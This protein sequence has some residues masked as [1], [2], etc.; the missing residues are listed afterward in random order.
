MVCYLFRSRPSAP[1]GYLVVEVRR[2]LP[3]VDAAVA[4]RD[5]SG[6]GWIGP[7]GIRA[8]AKEF[9]Q[10]G[11]HYIIAT[12]GLTTN[13]GWEQGGSSYAE[14]AERELIRSGVSKNKIIVAPAREA[15]SRRTYESAV[16]VWQALGQGYSSRCPQCVH[17][18]SSRQAKSFGFRKGL[19]ARNASWRRRLGSVRLRRHGMV[20]L[21][22]AGKGTAYGN[23]RLRV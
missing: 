19:S 18:G 7:E 5:S 23:R 4:G 1:F 8:A 9:E 21:Q 17:V 14:M 2:V 3:F 20:A 12:G 11:Y 13:E 16:A 22:R 6:G 10:R 15:K